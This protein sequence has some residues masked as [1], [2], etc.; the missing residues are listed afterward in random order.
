MSRLSS[1][2]IPAQAHHHS[3][4]FMVLLFTS[5]LFLMSAKQSCL[6][7][8][9][10][11]SVSSTS[12]LF[13]RSSNLQDWLNEDDDGSVFSWLGENFLHLSDFPG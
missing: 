4:L 13:A 9:V 7:L 10:F 3:G 5:E 1:R 6:I 12:L 11:T 8:I 2:G